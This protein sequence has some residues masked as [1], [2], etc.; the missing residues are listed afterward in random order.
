MASRNGYPKLEE[1]RDPVALAESD[2][3]FRDLALAALEKERIERGNL[4]RLLH[5]EVAPILS[6]AG[7]QL[8]ILRMDLENRVPGISLRTA[9]IQDLLER[10][11][12]HIRDL[13]CELHADVVKRTGLHPALTLLVSRFQRIFPGSVRLSYDNSIH[14]PVEAEVA[15]ERVANEAVANAVRHAHCTQIDILVQSAGGGAKL[16]VRDNGIGFDYD[17]ELQVPRG[18]GLLMMD[19]CSRKSGLHLTIDGNLGGGSEVTAVLM[20]RR[21]QGT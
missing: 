19:F 8:D 12:S 7:L 17:R 5:D 18:L 10:V 4:A 11:V 3:R 14:I 6:G 21:T 1:S 13:S 15:L 2:Q 9:E 16:Q 20:D